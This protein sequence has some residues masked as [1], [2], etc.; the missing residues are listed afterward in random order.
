VPFLDQGNAVQI[1]RIHSLA[2]GKA[3]L[4]KKM[5]SSDKAGNGGSLCVQ[6][7]SKIGGKEHEHA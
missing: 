5:K 6:G 7:L 1:S 3:F 2:V 4:G